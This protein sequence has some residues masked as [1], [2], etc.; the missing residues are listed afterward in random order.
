MTR[1]LSTLM[2]AAVSVSIGSPTVFAEGFDGGSAE[3]IV[4]DSRKL[5]PTHVLQLAELDGSTTPN[6]RN[7]DTIM[8]MNIGFG[9]SAVLAGGSLVYLATVKTARMG[10]QTG[11]NEVIN[12][13]SIHLD[14]LVR[15]IPGGREAVLDGTASLGQFSNDVFNV[16][17]SLDP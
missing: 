5:I 7:Q 1:L 9:V 3:R 17:G 4:E 2:I 11:V 15:D 10:S 12:R 14:G 8:G 16:L 6:L 13:G